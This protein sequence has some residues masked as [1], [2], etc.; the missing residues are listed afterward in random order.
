MSI[1]LPLHKKRFDY[2]TYFH[3]TANEERYSKLLTHYELFKRAEKVK[4]DIIECGVFK[5][6]S[7]VRFCFFLKL[8]KSK[9]KIIGFDNFSNNY[10]KTSEVKDLKIRSKWIKES[11]GNSISVVQLRKILN[12]NNIKNFELIKGDVVKTI[13]KFL[14]K[15]KK[16]KIALLNID[17]DFYE[18]TK[19]CLTNLFKHV[20]KNGIILLDNYNM[21][22]GETNS[23]KEFFLNQKKKYK[24]QKLNFSKKPYFV[25]K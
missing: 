18:S 11:G 16:L 4:G 22:Y 9:K 13:P 24:F 10:P 15:N 19:A 7:F 6:T 17:I 3:L 14:K 21:G 1:I 20:S 25:I 12:K 2:E 5:G 8:Y 23:I